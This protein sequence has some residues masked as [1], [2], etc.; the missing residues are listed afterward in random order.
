M[1]GIAINVMNAR[2]GRSHPR[3]PEC[4]RNVRL[5]HT[6]V[7]MEKVVITVRQEV[8]PLEI[9]VLVNNALQGNIVPE[10][11][12]VIATLVK[13]QFKGPQVALL[14]LRDRLPKQVVSAGLVIQVLIGTPSRPRMGMSSVRIVQKVLIKI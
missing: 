12:V 7:S 3:D 11:C 10:V 1:G 6:G 8:Y 2:L 4:V 14:A 5:E 13:V 9:I